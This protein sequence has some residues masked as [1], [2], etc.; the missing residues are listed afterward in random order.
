MTKL[1]FFFFFPVIIQPLGQGAGHGGAGAANRPSDHRGNGPS[2]S[3]QLLC[4]AELREL[5]DGRH[6][7]LVAGRQTGR[8]ALQRGFQVR[9]SRW[10]TQSGLAILSAIKACTQMRLNTK[11]GQLK[12][13]EL[14]M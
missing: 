5:E 8:K 2:H 4:H 11:V 6:Q 7:K 14:H 12:R 13:F 1:F 3:H 10:K 9:D